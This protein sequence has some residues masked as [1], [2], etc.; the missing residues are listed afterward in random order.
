MNTII[1]YR[2]NGDIFQEIEYTFINE[3][4]KKLKLLYTYYDSDLY[5]QLLINENILNKCNKFNILL[6]SQLSKNDFI[7][8]IFSSKKELYCLGCNQQGKYLINNNIQDNYSKL[9]NGIIYNYNNSYNIIKN[10]SY[11]DLIILCI[12][13][14]ADFFQFISIDLLNDKKFLLKAIKQNENVLYYFNTNLIN[15][16]KKFMLEAINNNGL[17]LSFASI[18]LQNDKDIVL[19]AVKQ[20]G[21]S[22]IYASI[23]LQNDKDIVLEAVKQNRLS[24]IYASINLQNDKDII[25]EVIK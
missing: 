11:K 6:L 9:L 25:L 20:N 18:N 2:L 15:N 23:N 17:I 13:Q 14:Y 21:L 10:T 12:D 24:L 7:T 5:I 22:L 4:Y 8:I 16:D 3:L 19:E 1:I